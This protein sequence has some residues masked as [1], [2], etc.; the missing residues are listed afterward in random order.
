MSWLF[1][2]VSCRTT[3]PEALERRFLLAIL[4]VNDP[5]DA[6]DFDLSDA[7]IDAAPAI[8]GEQRTLRAVI[9]NHNDRLRF[10][11]NQVEFDIGTDTPTIRVGGTGKGALPTILGSLSINGNTGGADRIELDGSAAG[12]AASGLQLRGYDCVIESLVINRFAGHGMIISGTGPP[13]E[14]GH[15]IRNNFIGTDSAG[16][17]DLG[18]GGHGVFIEGGTPNNTIGGT[19]ANATNVISGNGGDG[20][21]IDAEI[22]DRPPP[23]GSPS[24]GI[25]GNRIGVNLTGA[26]VLG[27]DGDG[28]RVLAHAGD[29]IQ[30]NLISGNAMNGVDLVGATRIQ[31]I[32]NRIGTNGNETASL[33]NMMNGVRL[34][35]APGNT[36]G[37]ATSGNVIS[38]NNLNGVLVFGSGSSLNSIQGNFIGTSHGQGIDLGN[39][40]SGIT[41]DG[42]SQTAIGGLLTADTRNVIAFNRAHGVRITGATATHNDLTGNAIGTDRTGHAN[43]GNGVHGVLVESDASEN[44]IGGAAADQGNLIAFNGVRAAPTVHGHGVVIGSGTRNAIRRNYIYNNLGRGIDLGD[45]SFTV[46]DAGGDPDSGANMVQ[47][48]PV[49]LSVRFAGATRTIEWVLNSAANTTFAIDFFHNDSPDPSGF[50]EGQ[51][52]IRNRSVVTNAHGNALFSETFALTDTFISATATDP[53]GNTSEFSPVDTD[54]DAIADA[55]ETRG[56]DYDEDGAIDLALAGADPNHKDLYVEADA[57]AAR[58]PTAAAIATARDGSAGSGGFANASNALVNNP[59]GTDGI[60]LHVE[61][62]ESDIPAADIDANFADFDAIKA[63][64]FGSAA[65]RASPAAIAAKKLV[66]RYVLF[67][68][69]YDGGDSSGYAELPLL[70]R[71]VDPFARNDFIITLGA[72]TPAGGTNDQQAGTLMHEM[73]HTLG[74]HHGGGDEDNYKPNYHSVMNYTWQVPQTGYAASWVPDY[75]RRAFPDL[76][77]ASLDETAGIGGHTGHHVAI[78][79][80]IGTHAPPENVAEDGPV[81]WNRDGDTADTAISRDVNF[82]GDTNGDGS[83]TAADSTPGN[84]LAGYEDWSHLRY[85]FVESPAFADG[86]HGATTAHLEKTYVDKLR[87]DAIGGAI[88]NHPPVLG[89]IGN[90]QVIAGGELTFTAT[91]TDADV[92]DTLTFSLDA[93]APSGA[94]VDPVTGVFRFPAGAGPG[95]FPVTLRVA[96]SGVP[97]LSDF[98]TFMIEVIPRRNHA[99]KAKNDHYRTLVGQALNVV[100]PGVLGNDRDRDGDRLTAALVE[101][102]FHG[103][104]ALQPD[105][106]FRYIPT[107]DFSGN[108]RFVYHGSDG[109]LTSAPVRVM[110]QV[111]RADRHQARHAGDGHRVVP[112]PL[113]RPFGFS[114]VPVRDAAGLLSSGDVLLTQQK[115]TLSKQA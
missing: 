47:D 54:G 17:V 57:M 33:G 32:S 12:A 19:A 84:T 44:R 55:W 98:E 115:D 43:L 102:P 21:H 3:I 65:Q 104:L 88:V 105:G 38:G 80:Q 85:Y 96:D 41:I 48:Y 112:A 97:A 30:G 64:R 14:G 110:I 89:T 76:D 34:E 42:A 7:I 66:Y 82:L 35:G 49:V 2:P 40:Q 107:R 81:D 29:V 62:N 70:D 73:G 8:P 15:T 94:T 27:N 28:V 100:A 37:A 114:L 31:V 11:P 68:D 74:L 9:E 6:G 24:N 86:A 53:D 75:S 25:I 83:I 113:A 16:A 52:F 93:G 61:V 79:P 92:G 22:P 77:E 4:T 67:G 106:S 56:V 18:N 60:S 87:L 10:E 50:G 90:R 95:L 103:T 111:K 78:G 101:G 45:D 20:V 71:P 69:T 23:P 58:A 108:D 1:R 13:G 91:A 99:P 5:G 72:W 39:Q 51:R 59:D 63:A 26:A 36:I 109:L 46:N